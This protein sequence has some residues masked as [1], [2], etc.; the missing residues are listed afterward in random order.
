M[1]DESYSDAIF[2]A[3]GKASSASGQIN[4]A[5][6]DTPDLTHTTT[7]RDDDLNDDIAQFL[8]THGMDETEDKPGIPKDEHDR[9]EV[10]DPVQSWDASS[11]DNGSRRSKMVVQNM[12]PEL[13][14]QVLELLFQSDSAVDVNISSES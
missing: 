8:E 9:R 13:V 4:T 3:A 5:F 1:A 12:R 10:V 2:G 7:P 14:G 6:A 11:G